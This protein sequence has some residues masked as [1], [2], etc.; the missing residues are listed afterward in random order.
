MKEVKTNL[1]RLDQLGIGKK[2]WIHAHAAGSLELMLMEMGCV[3]GE[4][5]QVEMI[6]PLGDPI[7]IQV[8]GYYLSLRKQDAAGIMVSLVA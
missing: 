1:I 3:P 7:A 4:I 5:I 6:A 8:A 2:A